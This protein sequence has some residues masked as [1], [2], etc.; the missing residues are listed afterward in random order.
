M[1]CELTVCIFGSKRIGAGFVGIGARHVVGFVLEP[2]S[3]QFEAL[4]SLR[5]GPYTTPPVLFP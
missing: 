2:D 1:V 5:Q 4:P 3:K